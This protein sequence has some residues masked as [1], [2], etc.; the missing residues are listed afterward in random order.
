MLVINYIKGSG[1]S[2]GLSSEVLL[3]GPWRG[4]KREDLDMV[5]KSHRQ[6]VRS[7]D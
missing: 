2:S 4:Q 1:Q 6:A 7:Y 3:R 5:R